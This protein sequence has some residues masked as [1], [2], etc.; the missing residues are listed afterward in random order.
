[1]GQQVSG[2]TREKVHVEALCK[3]YR[4][5]M[6]CQ[7]L[8]GRGADSKR[9]GAKGQGKGKGLL[10]SG[11]TK[12]QRAEHL[13]SIGCS[14]NGA[15]PPALRD[16]H[17]RARAGIPAWALEPVLFLQCHLVHTCS[18]THNHLLC[19]AHLHISHF[20]LK[21]CKVGMHPHVTGE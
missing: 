15:L 18:K 3:V 13:L 5:S 8:R 9:Q 11:Q 1:M 19:C 16:G 10:V 7:V 6:V 21:I 2:F 17:P 14:L 12:K 4:I 20:T